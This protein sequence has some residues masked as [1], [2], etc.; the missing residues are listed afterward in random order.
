M[1]RIHF[2]DFESKRHSCTRG[3]SSIVLCTFLRLTQHTYD[4]ILPLK[5]RCRT[6]DAQFPNFHARA[7][8]TTATTPTIRAVLGS[9]Y[10]SLFPGPY[11]AKVCK[12]F[13]LHRIEAGQHNA[14]ELTVHKASIAKGGA[15]ARHRQPPLSAGWVA[16]SAQHQQM[17]K[18]GRQLWV[19]I[20]VCCMLFL[21]L[22][23]LC[24]AY[25]QMN[26]AAAAGDAAAEA[27]RHTSS[28]VVLVMPSPPMVSG[29]LTRIDRLGTIRD[30]WGRDLVQAGDN[31]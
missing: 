9:M 17:E 26:A 29:P 5:Y 13:L 8:T 21:A 23:Q 3:C 27:R 16:A 31:R 24:T 4:A 11:P 7:A 18:L 25:Y 30:T 14:P 2:W 10:T 22:H 15:Y 28:V 1:R 12:P 20:S 19:T 6:S